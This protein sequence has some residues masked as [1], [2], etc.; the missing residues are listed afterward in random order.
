MENLCP[1]VEVH[2]FA[3]IFPTLT[4]SISYSP[5]CAADGILDSLPYIRDSERDLLLLCADQLSNT[6]K[7]LSNLWQ[8]AQSLRDTAR[9]LE[10]VELKN[11]IA[12]RDRLI[13]L[14][15]IVLFVSLQGAD[16]IDWAVEFA[17]DEVAI[18]RSGAVS[19]WVAI[20]DR[21]P[22]AVESL[23][24]LAHGKW[25][26]RLV[27]AKVIGKLGMK[28]E[29]EELGEKLSKDPVS[30][31]RYCMAEGVRGTDWFERWFE[32]NSDPDILMIE[33]DTQMV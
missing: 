9:V 4:A 10:F 22:E 8:F 26:A 32:E 16:L 21:A 33:G 31:I 19:L 6:R 30:N 7:F 28:K 25:H 18:V 13:L 14:N 11:L 29:W 2:G 3:P 17:H 23:A 15:Q 12:W 24:R 1:I 27:A 20:I 5:D